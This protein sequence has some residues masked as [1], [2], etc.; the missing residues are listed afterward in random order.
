M[1]PEIHFFP[2]MDENFNKLLTQGEYYIIDD[3]LIDNR[4]K[5]TLIPVKGDSNRQLVR[6]CCLY[7]FS[8]LGLA[9]C[10]FDKRESLQQPKCR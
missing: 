6:R 7:H 8:E 5:T 10:S 2:S 1:T 3:M 9:W 4:S